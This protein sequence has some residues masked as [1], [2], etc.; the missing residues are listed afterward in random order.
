MHSHSG[1]HWLDHGWLRNNPAW[2]C[3][4]SRRRIQPVCLLTGSPI[5]GAISA[6]V[7]SIDGKDAGSFP[8]G[9]NYSGYLSAGQH[10]IVAQ[11]NPNLTGAGP[12]RKTAE[13][14]SRA[15]LFLYR[16]LVGREYDSGEEPGSVS[17]RLLKKSLSCRVSE[18]RSSL[19]GIA[20]RL[21]DNCRQLTADEKLIQ[22][23]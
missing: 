12:A 1:L 19:L 7:L 11:V 15:N 14:Q 16:G 18:S 23:K 5:S 8:D 20:A 13:R 17:A 22:R 9:R 6:L 2:C 10:V 4:R 3:G 21:A